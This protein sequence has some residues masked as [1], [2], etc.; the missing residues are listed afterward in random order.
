[1]ICYN[2]GIE[3]TNENKTAEH[4]PAKNL[5]AGQPAEVKQNLLTVPA[6][7]D[8]NN[9]FSNI[10]SEIRDIIG[11]SN[12]SLTENQVISEKAAKSLLRQIALL[13]LVMVAF[14]KQSVVRLKIVLSVT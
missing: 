6:C 11:I 9:K 12:D 14:M 4:I 2:C 13:R 5:Y 1:M 8:C 7:F 3:L 10:D